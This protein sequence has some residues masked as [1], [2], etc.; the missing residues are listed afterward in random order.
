MAIHIISDLHISGVDDP[1]YASLLRLILTRLQPGDVFVLAGDIFDLWVG[2][3][4]LFKNR[5]SAFI[6]SVHAAGSQGVKIQ[7]L[8]GNH[9]FH[10]KKAFKDVRGLRVHLGPIIEE[11]DGKRFYIDHGD[12]VDQGDYKYL[13]LRAV[14]RSPVLKLFSHAA[15]GKWIDWIGNTSSQ[16]SAQN[17]RQ[18]L[19]D[20]E[21]MSAVRKI[22]REFSKNLL[23]EGFDFVVL[24]H[25]HDLDEMEFK[26]GSR[27]AQY[28]NVGYPRMHH[29][30]LSWKAGDTH[31]RREP[32]P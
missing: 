18:T 27:V 25:C 12:R 17:S 10:L 21:K 16:K 22:F 7:Y 32:L 1:L 13:A 19:K 2:D 3:S 9:D 26:L 11:L 5:Y 30:Y 23:N 6:E 8:E 20:A 15:P 24:G 14:F 28:I 4:D 31:I 29:S